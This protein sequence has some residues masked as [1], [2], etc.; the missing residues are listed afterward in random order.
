MKLTPDYHWQSR[1]L[2]GAV[3]GMSDDRTLSISLFTS[4]SQQGVGEGCYGKTGRLPKASGPALL[5]RVRSCRRTARRSVSL[6]GDSLLRPETAPS[7]AWAGG[8]QSEFVAQ[9]SP[10]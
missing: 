6:D 8:S 5:S 1:D 4:S 10:V 2:S 7:F 3:W 9:R